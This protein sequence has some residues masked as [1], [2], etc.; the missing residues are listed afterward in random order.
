MPLLPPSGG[1][2]NVFFAAFVTC[3][4]GQEDNALRRYGESGVAR[5]D[6]RGLVAVAGQP[7]VIEFQL[8]DLDRAAPL[9]GVGLGGIGRPA[10]MGE[11]EQVAPGRRTPQHRRGR[12]GPCRPRPCR[13]DQQLPGLSSSSCS[14]RS[15]DTRP[16]RPPSG[17]RSAN[18]SPASGT[19]SALASVGHGP[20][21]IGPGHQVGL[22]A[23]K[24]VLPA[25]SSL[26]HIRQVPS[27]SLKTE[28]SARG[29]T[30]RERPRVAPRHEV[31]ARQ[32]HDPPIAGPVVEHPGT[33]VRNMWYVSSWKHVGGPMG[34]LRDF[35]R[36]SEPC[37]DTPKSYRR[38]P[39]RRC[40]S[41]CR[42][43]RKPR[44]DAALARRLV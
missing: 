40:R 19:P 38:R 9:F 18:S 33:T 31:G 3:P 34:G 24:I 35:D 14:R 5:R 44:R 43:P 17:R 42:E 29:P 20:A 12:R 6:A 25:C 23:K 28:A 26:Y 4:Q 16:A 22:S 41:A 10:G 30:R 7:A 36:A 1:C 37:R 8:D 39:I 21:A 27:G 13:G 15:S 32:V 11:V 2:V